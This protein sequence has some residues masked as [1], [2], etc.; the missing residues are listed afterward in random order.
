MTETP[1]SGRPGLPDAAYARMALV[2]RVGLL[3]SLLCFLAAIVAH[4]LLHPGAQW[5]PAEGNPSRAFLSPG[6]LAHGLAAGSTVAFLTLG[7]LLLVAT[8]LVRVLSGLYY[9][10]RNGERTIA[11]IAAAVFLM[12]VVGLFVLGPLIR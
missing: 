1:S 2:L 4:V 9:F 8:P 12:L 10:E 11:S 7:I 3:A 6:G 5:I